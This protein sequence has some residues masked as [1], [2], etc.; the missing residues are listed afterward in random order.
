MAKKKQDRGVKTQAIRDYLSANK[1]A[2]APEVVAALAEKG[3]TITPAAVY[4]LKARK[5]M[6]RRVR[7][8][9]AGGNE[10]GNGLVSIDG[11]IAAKKLVDSVGGFNQ[12]REAIDALAKLSSE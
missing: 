5:K 3:I 2:K 4:N 12:A 8:A 10:V 1:E 7:Q 11:L 9:R 6:K